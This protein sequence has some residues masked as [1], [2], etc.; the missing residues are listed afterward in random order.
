MLRQEKRAEIQFFVDRIL[1]WKRNRRACDI[2]QRPSLGLMVEGNAAFDQEHVRRVREGRRRDRVSEDV[3]RPGDRSGRTQCD[4][5]TQDS[6]VTALAWSKLQ[7]VGAENDGT[8]VSIGRSMHNMH[9]RHDDVLAQDGASSGSS[10][11][12]I[13][14]MMIMVVMPPIAGENTARKCEQAE[15]EKHIS[16]DFHE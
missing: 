2:E 3:I 6:P 7:S 1:E 12:I 8:T 14:I 11:A 16:G 15:A 5:K 9:G 4:V 10:L 13:A